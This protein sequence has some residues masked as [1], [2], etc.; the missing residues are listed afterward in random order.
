MS[1]S[2][3]DRPQAEDEAQRSEGAS[4]LLDLLCRWAVPALWGALVA[5]ACIGAAAGVEVRP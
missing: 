3:E 1:A 4:L 2:R 5:L